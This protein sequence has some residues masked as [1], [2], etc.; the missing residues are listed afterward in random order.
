M[1]QKT[2][3]T[4]VTIITV[5]VDGFCLLVCGDFFPYSIV[6]YTVDVCSFVNP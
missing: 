1:R 5:L 2:E 4:T 6:H 3:E